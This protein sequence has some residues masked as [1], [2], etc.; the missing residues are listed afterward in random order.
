MKELTNSLKKRKQNGTCWQKLIPHIFLK[1]IKNLGIEHQLYGTLK[2]PTTQHP[3]ESVKTSNHGLMLKAL[4]DTQSNCCD[5]SFSGL[6][7]NS[8]EMPLF[9]NSNDRKMFWALF[10]GQHLG[11]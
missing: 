5:I 9:F 8:I 11:N 6:M 2:T 4:R 7:S 10:L 3:I 1:C